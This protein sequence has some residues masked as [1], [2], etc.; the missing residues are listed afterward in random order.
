MGG[1]KSE[2][3][4]ELLNAYHESCKR[5]SCLPLLKEELKCKIQCRR[6]SR[7]EGE[8]K[9]EFEKQKEYKVYNSKFSELFLWY[10]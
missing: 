4:D 10:A 8:M 9:V 2:N 5:R 7:G 6:L 3:D 1:L